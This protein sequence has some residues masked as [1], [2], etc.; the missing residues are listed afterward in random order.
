L[1]RT[2][3]IAISQAHSYSLKKLAFVLAQ[4]ENSVNMGSSFDSA[5]S[6]N[7]FAKA[8]VIAWCSAFSL[9]SVLIVTGNL[10][11]IILFAVNKK[12]RKKCFFLVV[13]MACADLLVGAVSLPI[14]IITPLLREERMS[15]PVATFLNIVTVVCLQATITFAAL[16]SLER[17][18][19][20]CWPLKYRTLSGQAYN[21]VIILAWILV[22]LSST[23]LSVLRV[24]VYEVAYYSLWVTYT[25]TLT[26]IICV[27]T[28]GIWRKFENR[29][30]PS[31]TQQNRA[32]QSRRLTKTLMLVSLLALMSWIPIIIINILEATNVSVNKN[33]YLLAVLLNVS[34]CCANPVVYALRVSEFRKAFFSSRR[35]NANGGRSNR[36]SISTP[37]TQL[38]STTTDLKVLDTKL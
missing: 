6:N 3:I 12:V 36:Y 18:Y 37:A 27:C 20:T 38:K 29:R 22:L 1:E 10:L 33:I 21:V 14:K 9:I 5:T 4:F 11:T 13:N 15:L 17:V 8:E 30:M 23:I 26:F 28:L 34:N 35:M 24:F 31:L 32:L 2:P 19:A 16:I 7:A 25:F